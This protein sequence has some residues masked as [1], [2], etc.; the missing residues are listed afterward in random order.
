MTKQNQETLK[1]QR[2]IEIQNE[3]R[4]LTLSQNLCNQTTIRTN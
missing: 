1:K 3:K 4:K 2:Q